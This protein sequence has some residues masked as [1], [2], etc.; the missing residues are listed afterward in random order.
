MNIFNTPPYGEMGSQVMTRSNTFHP[1]WRCDLS[2][3]LPRRRRI[4][5]PCFAPT[6]LRFNAQWRVAQHAKSSHPLQ[7]LG[8]NWSGRTEDTVRRKH[9]DHG[10]MGWKRSLHLGCS[11]VR[12]EFCKV[13]NLRYSS[14]SSRTWFVAQPYENQLSDS[15]AAAWSCWWF[16]EFCD[17]LWCSRESSYLAPFWSSHSCCLAPQISPTSV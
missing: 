14:V 17:I 11:M 8:M 5:S 12:L 7:T 16:C 1:G 3:L 10:A 15:P 6:E 9:W 2:F 13:G 4:S